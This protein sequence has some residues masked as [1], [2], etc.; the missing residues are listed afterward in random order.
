MSRYVTLKLTKLEADALQVTM[1]MWLYSTGRD[2]QLD[3][4]GKRSAI[5]AAYDGL[6]K[7]SAAI[8]EAEK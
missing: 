2:E 5:R 3:L 6:K 8:R 4:Y 1:A 7:L